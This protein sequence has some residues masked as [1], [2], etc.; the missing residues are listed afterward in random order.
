MADLVVVVVVHVCTRNSE[1][2]YFNA[3]V[4]ATDKNQI[5]LSSSLNKL[6]I[7]STGDMKDQKVYTLDSLQHGGISDVI[8]AKTNLGDVP[9]ASSFS[10]LFDSTVST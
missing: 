8:L 2:N 7:S 6:I 3:A 4:T 10:A 5:S 1:E 9:L